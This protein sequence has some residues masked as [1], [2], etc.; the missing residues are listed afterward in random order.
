MSAPAARQRL[1]FI[2]EPQ[3]LPP[4]RLVCAL[5]QYMP[6]MSGCAANSVIGF[7]AN[8]SNGPSLDDCA[9]E[10]SAIKAAHPDIRGMFCWS[11][12]TNLQGG[13][14]WGSAMKGSL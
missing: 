10:W 13:N 7:S 1:P 3:P 2:A 11:A 5:Q 14:G 12:Q 6:R 4:C 9:R 8:Y